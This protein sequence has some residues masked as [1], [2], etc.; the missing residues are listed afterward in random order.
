MKY[1]P[2]Q[3]AQAL[4]EALENSSPKDESLVL[5]NFV[6]VLVEN[7][8]LRMFEEI[9]EEF[10]KLELRKKGLKQVEVTTARPITQENQHGIIQELNK[11]V[12]GN[13]E[14]K[15][16]V[17]ENLIGGV[18]IKVDDQMLDASVKNDLEQ[19]KKELI[20]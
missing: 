7:S 12:K 4:M 15:K 13:I 16:K 14:L 6:K 17:D 11:I 3:Y 19:L 2:K 18:I 8:H 9:S 1:S 20:Q 10:H 5:D